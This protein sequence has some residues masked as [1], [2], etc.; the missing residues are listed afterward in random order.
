MKARK[1]KL[2]FVNYEA[3]RMLVLTASMSPPVELAHRR[4][5]DWTWAHVH[6]PPNCPSVLAGIAHCE[7]AA[8]PEMAAS[9]VEHGWRAGR[10]SFSH[11][12]AMR[13][14]QQARAA[15]DLAHERAARGAR[16]RW[17]ENTPDAKP[18]RRLPAK[19]RIRPEPVPINVQSPP[20]AP[21]MPQHEPGIAQA[22][23]QAMPDDAQASAQAMPNECLIT[24]ND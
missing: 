7:P 1:E 20:A 22:S 18:K 21:A 11:P 14:L 24:I 17:Q 5:V 23:A 4:L 6:A 10:R 9:L 8:W 3:R 13:I 12:E 2:Y 16:A 15:Y 19:P